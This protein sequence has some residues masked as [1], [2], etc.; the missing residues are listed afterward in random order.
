MF[1]CFYLIDLGRSSTQWCSIY[2]YSN[3]MRVTAKDLLLIPRKPGWPFENR[4]DDG[5][6]VC[7]IS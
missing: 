4:T 2:K 1:H 6:K 3:F 5:E 7:Y